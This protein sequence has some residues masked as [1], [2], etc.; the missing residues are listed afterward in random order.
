[1]V[2][3]PALPG[4]AEEK[5]GAGK[6]WPHEGNLAA[7]HPQRLGPPPPA[8]PQQDFLSAGARPAYKAALAGVWALSDLLRLINIYLLLILFPFWCQGAQDKS[9]PRCDKGSRSQSLALPE[10]YAPLKTNILTKREISW[11][12]AALF[13]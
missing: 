8:G 10:I 4:D 1:M 12:G 11:H 2:R 13:N 6:V 9:P 7:S 3:V 5:R